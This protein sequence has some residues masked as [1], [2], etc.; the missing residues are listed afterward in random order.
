MNGSQATAAGSAGG[1]HEPAVLRF[2]RL[3]WGRRILIACGSLV[4]ALLVGAALHL[5]PSK[6]TVTFVYER[7]LTESEYN[8]LMRRFYSSENLGKIV[9]C[10]NESGVSSYAEKLE[11]AETEEAL[12]RLIRFTVSPA[13]PKR[14]QTT[15]PTTSERISSFQAQL[16]YIDISDDSEQDMA[17]VSGAVTANLENV[18][19]I[20]EIRNAL[21]ESIQQFKVRA[22][23]IEDNRFTLTLELDKERQKLGKLTRLGETPSA[24][25]EDNVVLE[26]T[27]VRESR[28]FL[29]L[30]Y[31]VRAVQSKIIDLEERLDSDQEKYSYYLKIL[32]LNDKLLRVIEPS[33]LTYYTAGQFLE[34]LGSQLLECK[35]DALADYL[36]SYI[37]KTENLVLVN[38]RAGEKPVVYPVPKHVMGRSV[39]AF[40]VLFMMAA[41][42][43]V[44][45]E[46]R[47][48]RRRWFHLHA[49]SQAARE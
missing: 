28:D 9:S 11:Q 16:L 3:L 12:E 24:A 31:Q 13:Y 32:D 42:V 7:P 23:E 14:L 36:K 10:L 22:A 8:V 41:F 5:W 20:Y 39:L 18:L 33:I 34:F 6:Y 21:K 40:V 2:F 25:T 27:D 4:P 17:A 46:Y 35:D 30:P 37:R 38:T 1:E 49:G 19:P 47:R 43:A 26:F 44:A 48:E 29:P 15:D 45:L